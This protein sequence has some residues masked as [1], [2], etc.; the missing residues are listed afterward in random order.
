MAPILSR[1]TSGGSGGFGFGKKKQGGGP[2][3]TTGG[4]VED[5][6]TRPGYKLH[7]FTSPG[8]LTVSGGPGTVELFMVGAGGGGGT[9]PIPGS[10]GGGGGGGGAWFYQ[11]ITLGAG[12]HPVTRGDGGA[13]GPYAPRPTGAGGDGQA[14]TIVIG[15]TTYTAAGGGGAGGSAPPSAVS[16]N[17][18]GYPG[19]SGGTA[20]LDVFSPPV[21]WGNPGGTTPPAAV[22]PTYGA[23]GGGG[24]S[25]VGQAGTN[26]GGGDAG[27]GVGLSW[28]P[29][30]YGTTGPNG[31]GRYFGGG[32]G[33][34]A[35]NN[36]GPGGGGRS[37]GGNGGAGTGGPN[38]VSGTAN[39]GSGGG[40]DSQ[41]K[42]AGAGGSGIV[43]IAVPTA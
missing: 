7:I 11:E 5:I 6:S 32:G 39:T 4:N 10:S 21:G 17:R 3:S 14:S 8:N 34:S 19:G 41:A 30:S 31:S 29:A 1:L 36:G 20:N 18:D 42:I 15:A 16:T 43:I 23:S 35:Y 27:F 33:G 25:Q 40:G 22:G 28:V 12:T 13:A 37:G 2:L 9:S 26:T 24:A 38:A